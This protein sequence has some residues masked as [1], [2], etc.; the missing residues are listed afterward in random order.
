MLPQHIA[1][2]LCRVGS[3]G[4]VGMQAGVPWHRLLTQK[5]SP[6][7][8]LVGP[9]I[10]CEGSPFQ[11]SVQAEWRRNPHVQSFVLATDQVCAQTPLEQG[12]D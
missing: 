3:D 1:G 5:L 2:I 10:N 6:D 11:G 9:T 7:V 8:K 4:M 12:R